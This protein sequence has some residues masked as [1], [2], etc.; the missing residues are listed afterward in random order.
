MRYDTLVVVLGGGRPCEFWNWWLDPAHIPAWPANTG[1][2]GGLWHG[3][4]FMQSYFVLIFRAQGSAGAYPAGTR[5]GRR[6]AMIVTKTPS[7]TLRL[8]CAARS[9]GD[10]APDLTDNETMD[11]DRRPRKP[12]DLA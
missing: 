5:R 4:L 6:V 9:K 10:V 1:G 2:D 11:C 3:F 12:R 8:E 7:D